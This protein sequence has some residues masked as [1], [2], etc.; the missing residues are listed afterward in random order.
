MSRYG[1]R[2]TVTVMVFTNAAALG[3]LALGYLIGVVPVVAGL[4]VFGFAQGAWDV[5]MN[6]QGAQVERRL[7]RAIM[8]RFHAGFSVGTVGGAL[9]G[10]AMVALGVPVTVHLGVAAV[11]IAAIVPVAVRG[12]LPDANDPDHADQ[13]EGGS[14][15][16]TLSA[17][18]EPRTLRIGIFVLCFAFAEGTGNDWTAIALIDGYQTTAAVGTLGFAVFLAAMT[19]GR[20]FGPSLLDRYGRVVVVRT[21]AAI[22]VVGIVLFVFGGLTPVAF[23]GAILWGAGLSLGFPVGMSAGADEPA[24]AAPRVSV[25]ASIGYCAFLAGPP[26]IGFLGDHYTVLRALTTVAVLLAR[27]RAARRLDPS[28]GHRRRAGSD[29]GIVGLLEPSLHLGVDGLDVP[30]FEVVHP[31]RRRRVHDLLESR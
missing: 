11:L 6:V 22:S 9:V 2:R 14:R 30:E 25:I 20:W 31:H 7:G 18:R 29:R 10:A 23:V 26:L 3:V 28:A 1:S 4:F 15:R 19:A 27:R 17:W 16:R 12:F 8:P 24:M 13:Q 5:A 21:M